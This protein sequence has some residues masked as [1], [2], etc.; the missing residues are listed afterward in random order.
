MNSRFEAINSKVRPDDVI[1]KQRAGLFQS[2]IIIF[3]DDQPVIFYRDGK[4]CHVGKTDH[5]L[6]YI[7]DKSQKHNADSVFYHAANDEYVD[8]LLIAIMIYYD[9]SLSKVRPKKIHRKY[10]TIQQ[11]C[12]AY[13]YADSVSKKVVLSMIDS[14]HLRT[15]EIDADKK[16]IDKTELEAAI[17]GM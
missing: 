5:L 8:D 7:G 14:N 13:R 3:F 17:R 1:I 10:A 11:A 4:V 2:S 16:L 6:K 12:Y 15:C 9:L